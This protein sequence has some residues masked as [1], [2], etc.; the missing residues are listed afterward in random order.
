MPDGPA[1]AGGG[2]AEAAIWAAHHC[3]RGGCRARAPLSARRVNRVQQ[4]VGEHLAC[5]QLPREPRGAC[6]GG[7]RLERLANVQLPHEP[8]G[9]CGGDGRLVRRFRS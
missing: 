7:S 4:G 3:G 8:R 1:Y 6:A 9:A 2:E 5:V